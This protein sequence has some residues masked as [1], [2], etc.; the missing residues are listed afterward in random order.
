MDVRMLVNMNDLLNDT[1]M[2]APSYIPGDSYVVP[3]WL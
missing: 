2:S 3:F 1:C